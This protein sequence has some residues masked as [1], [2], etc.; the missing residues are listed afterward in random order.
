EGLTTQIGSGAEISAVSD[1]TTVCDLRTTDVALG[2]QGAPLVPLGEQL[3]FSDH[4]TFINLGG[5]ANISIHR[6]DHVIGYDIGPCNMILN[7]LA[8]EAGKNYDEDGSIARSGAVNDDLLRSLNA[9]D[10]YRKDPPRSL[11]REWFDKYVRPLISDHLIPLHDRMRTAVEH[12]AIQIGKE[13]DR[14]NAEQTMITGGGAHNSFLIERIG[15]NTKALIHLP[16]KELI[17]FKEALIF[18]LLGVLRIREEVNALSSVTGARINSI[19]G[20]LYC[21]SRS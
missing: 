17:D 10:F 4:D 15:A 8:T 7:I 3:L 20:A 2:G 18:A 13:L 6:E 1:I 21:T 12:E 16:E 9:L 19:G 14:H 5:I 11:G